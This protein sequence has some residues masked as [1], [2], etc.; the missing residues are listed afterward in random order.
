MHMFIIKRKMLKN[1]AIYKFMHTVLGFTLCLTLL[2]GY[3]YGFAY[4][5]HSSNPM[6][7]KV[8]GFGFW[9]GLGI[10]VGNVCSGDGSVKKRG[11]I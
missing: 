8:M 9:L 7:M 5:L 4:I 11:D 10:A 2:G 1:T 3:I 6:W